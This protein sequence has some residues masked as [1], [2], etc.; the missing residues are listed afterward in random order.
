MIE[1]LEKFPTL[2]DALISEKINTKAEL[3]LE[4]E[5]S[6]TSSILLSGTSGKGLT[7][8][9]VTRL[10]NRPKIRPNECD[11]VFSFS[12]RASTTRVLEYSLS[13][14]LKGSRSMAPINALFL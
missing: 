10:T 5:K 14:V 11:D 2:A 12:C 4:L 9:G 13:L 8:G 7:P 1:I 3:I 6:P